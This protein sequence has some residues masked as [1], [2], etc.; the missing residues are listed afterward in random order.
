MLQDCEPCLKENLFSM[1]NE[2][3]PDIICL[4]E[5]KAEERQVELPE[6]IKTKYP[7]R[8]WESTK[9]TTQRKGFSGTTIWSKINPILQYKAP[10]IDE[11]GRIIT[12]EFDKFIVMC[13]Y[14]PNSQNLDSSRL[15]FRTTVWH[16]N[17]K[18]YII[19]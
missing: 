19:N 3:N 2:Y 13:V 9:G 8:F 17:F 12:L 14:T 6:I 11:E 1:I 4:Q 5:T 15:K 10:D 18:E 7:Y 16:E